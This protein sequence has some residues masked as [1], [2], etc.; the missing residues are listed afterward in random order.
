MLIYTINISLKVSLLD[1][2]P[3]LWD[4]L[5]FRATILDFYLNQIVI[6]LITLH[7]ENYQ[8]KKA[9]IWIPI[10]FCLGS[11]GT[12]LYFLYFLNLKG[13]SN[14]RLFTR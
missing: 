3:I 10:Y 12:A 6:W 1:S 8:I 13:S 4:K 11:M 5:W 14:D 9:S 2:L 7:L